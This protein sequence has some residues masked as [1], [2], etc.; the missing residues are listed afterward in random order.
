MNEKKR[1]TLYVFDFD[2]TLVT[3]SNVIRVW[4]RD[5][6]MSPFNAHEFLNHKMRSGDWADF[7]TFE[8]KLV[9]PRPIKETFGL[10]LSAIGRSGLGDAVVVL[11]ARGKAAP[12]RKFMLGMGITKTKIVALGNSRSTAKADW[13]E[14]QLGA[15]DDVIF[16]DD[17]L[18]YLK[19]ARRVVAKYP[20]KTIVTVRV[21]SIR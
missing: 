6:S 9:D 17:H 18:P 10:F 12:I 16:Y 14:A 4:H 11:T 15:F 20:A 2:D 21:K 5:G 19:A 8:K 13:I 1:H 7:E 3:T